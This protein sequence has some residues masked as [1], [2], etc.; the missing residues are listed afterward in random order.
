MD[1]VSPKE[2]EYLKVSVT[3]LDQRY[4]SNPIPASTDPV[5]DFTVSFE[6]PSFLDPNNML[7]TASPMVLVLQKYRLEERAIVLST[8]RIDWR[9]L[10]SHNSV[11]ITKEMQPI[12]LKHKGSLGIMYIE[13]DVHPY[14]AKDQLLTNDTIRKQQ[15]LE[16]KFETEAQQQFLDYAKE[17]YSEYKEIRASHTKRLVKIFAETDDRSSVYTP[18]CS[19]IYPLVANK[20]IDS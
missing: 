9:D 4:S 15:D 3:F 17:W 19:L 1:F 13:L 5:F 7:T 10:L 16:K 6:I 8:E 20:L 11:E 12:D 14:L 18:T 2:D